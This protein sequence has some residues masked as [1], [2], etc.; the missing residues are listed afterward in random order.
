MPVYLLDKNVM[1][2][3]VTGIA[4]ARLGRLLP[5]DEW[6][7]LALLLK[8]QR[9]DVLLFVPRELRNILAH[10]RAQVEASLG[11]SFVE[12]ME[13]GRYL[14]RWARRLRN[15]GFTREDATLLSYGTFGVG[16]GG[17][18]LGATGIITLDRRFIRNF[19]IQQQVLEKRL[20]AMTV[21][22]MPPY[23][24]AML[25]MVLEPETLLQ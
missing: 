9:Q 23:H 18:V 1:R 3:A 25:P 14:K 13:H 4:R 24:H 2:K 12:V 5:Q 11:L 21:Q 8:C 20:R 7:C 15:Y 17:E 19:E 10:H 22:L 6:T 16:R